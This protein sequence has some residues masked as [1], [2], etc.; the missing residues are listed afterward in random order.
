MLLQHFCYLL[1]VFLVIEYVKAD[2]GHHDHNEHHDHLHNDHHHDHHHNDHH[3]DH[4]NNDEK[5]K[6]NGG[7]L[8]L[9][10]IKDCTNSINLFP[11]FLYQF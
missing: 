8:A 9:P 5:E 11:H 1:L 3:H 6:P 4:Q 2:H 10:N 7:R